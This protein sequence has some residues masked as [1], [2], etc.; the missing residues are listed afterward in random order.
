MRLLFLVFLLLISFDSM[1]QKKYAISFTTENYKT[2]K[3]NIPLTFKDSITAMRYINEFQFFAVSEGYLTASVDSLKFEKDHCTITFY[4]GEKFEQVELILDEEDKIF[5]ERQS[6]LKEKYL[7]HVPFRPNELGRLMKNIHT[8]TVSN[9]YPFSKVYLENLEYSG[10]NLTGHLKISEGKKYNFTEI[11]IKGDSSISGIFISNLINI[12]PGDPFDESKLMAI[13]KTL[14]QISFIKEIKTHE[15]L[16]TKEGIELY[17]YLES[18]PVS[19]INGVV[20]LQPNSVTNRIG[21]VGE[22]NM[23]LLNVLKRGELLNLN[24]RS[25]QAQTQ[26]LNGKINYPFLFKTPFGIDAMFKLYKRDSTFLELK[27]RLGVQYF[28]RGGNYLTAF[29]SNSSSNILSGAS[30]NPNFINLSTIRSNSYGLSFLRKQLDYLPN[31]T[32]GFALNTEV[33]VGTRKSQLNDT[34]VVEKSTIYSSAFQLDFFLPL[35]ARNV[36]HF[37]NRSSLYYAPIIFQNEVFRFGG[38]ATLRGFNEEELYATVIT[39]FSLEYR[40]LLDRNSH[41]FA[42]FDQGFYEN[43]SASYY[44]DHPFG[45]G[46]GLSF[47]TSIGM[48]S[49]SYGLG[50]QFDNPILIKNGKIHFGY[51]AYF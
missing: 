5:L 22:L 30:N 48:F 31:P 13:S 25:I 23:N 33:S 28:L 11:H 45:F 7:A 26:A 10:T 42:F 9:G 34:S 21:V 3:K 32:K 37:V 47:G 43:N 51:I 36:L 17:L 15:L 46:A 50:K 8:I 29:Y 14:K 40:F 44:K 20:G 12:R 19:S 4:T 16:F 27:S 6:N 24:W 18:K 38:Q 41:V 49:I 1:S 2:V 39:V 35:S